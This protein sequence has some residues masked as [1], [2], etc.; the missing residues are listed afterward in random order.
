MNAK[1]VILLVEP[2]REFRKAVRKILKRLGYKVITASDG[3]EALK[4]LSDTTVDLILSALMM[5]NV[6]GME[7]MDEVNRAKINV[8]V[9][10]LTA[11]GDVESYMDLMNKG[12]FDYLNKPV[13]EHEVLRVTKSALGYSGDFHFVPSSSG[14]HAFA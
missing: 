12:A 5:P 14:A 3:G 8:P 11:Y 13:K 7:L 6:D 1:K 4:L 2:D 9:V 10:F